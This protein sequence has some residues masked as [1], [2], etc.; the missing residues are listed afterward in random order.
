MTKERYAALRALP[1]DAV[2]CKRLDE[3]LDEIDRLQTE[4]ESADKHQSIVVERLMLER[5]RAR[6]ALEERNAPRPCGECEWFDNSLLSNCA[7]KD[8]PLVVRST[9][10]FGCRFWQ[11]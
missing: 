3:A 9:N 8:G 11:W 4:N 5:D 10:D 1:F 6:Q 7:H 2:T